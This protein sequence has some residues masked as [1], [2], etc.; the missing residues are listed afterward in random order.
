MRKVSCPKCGR[1]GTLADAEAPSAN[2]NESHISFSPPEGF[3]KVQLGWNGNELYLF[4]T[5]CGVAAVLA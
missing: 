3:R 1:S 2:D 4:C 5:C